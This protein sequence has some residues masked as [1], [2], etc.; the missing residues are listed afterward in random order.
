MDDEERIEGIYKGVVARGELDE[1]LNFFDEIFLSGIEKWRAK[2]DPKKGG[3]LS[4]MSA[5]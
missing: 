2:I 5:F 4:V 3:G 1:Q